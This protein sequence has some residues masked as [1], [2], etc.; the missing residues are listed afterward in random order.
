MTS[1]AFD[2]ICPACSSALDVPPFLA[3]SIRELIVKGRT[4]LGLTERGFASLVGVTRGA[5][6]QWERE[7]GT[8]PSKGRKD[9]VAA[10]LGMTTAEFITG[11]P[12]PLVAWKR[13][14]VRVISNVE[15][16]GFT[17]VDNLIPHG[18]TE[19]VLVTVD[20]NRHTFALRVRGDSMRGS[21]AVS[22]PEGTIIVV[23][24]EMKPNDGDFVVVLNAKKQAT[25]KQFV[26]VAG[27][28]HLKPLNAAFKTE[29]LGENEVIGVVRESITRFK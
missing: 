8:A 9:A 23:E 16:G 28:A 2:Q 20:V 12:R 26:L 15:A 10:L 13:R 21:G 24:P 4:R 27:T 29:P 1:T 22:F 18:D 3:S 6:Q 14:S 5:V 19:T 17:K 7:G 11:G 25:F